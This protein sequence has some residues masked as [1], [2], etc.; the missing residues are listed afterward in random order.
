MNNKK[1]NDKKYYIKNRIR[2]LSRNKMYR[3]SNKNKISLQKKKYYSTNKDSILIKKKEYFKNN[4]KAISEYHK[5]CRIFNKEKFRNKNRKYYLNNRDKIQSYHKKYEKYKRMVD[6][7]YKLS[8][9]LRSRLYK[10]IKNVCKSGSAVKDLGCSIQEL[11]LHIE[12]QF[13]LGMSWDNYGKWGWHIDHVIP[14]SLFNLSNRDDF[15]KANHYTNLQPLWSKDN[16]LK[17][18]KLI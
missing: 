16:L 18:D 13:K 1:E 9:N 17:S 2:I 5:L 6:I 12:K 7:N 15:L 11:K 8:G 4:K 3:N 10:A 14:L